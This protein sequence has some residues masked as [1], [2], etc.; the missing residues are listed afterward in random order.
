MYQF[1]KT[2]YLGLLETAFGGE[3]KKQNLVIITLMSALEDYAILLKKMQQQYLVEKA[4]T[5]EMVTPL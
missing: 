3:I 2:T 1:N 4:W 5:S